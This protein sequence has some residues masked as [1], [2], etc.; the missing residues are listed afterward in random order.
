MKNIIWHNDVGK[1]VDDITNNPSEWFPEESE[2]EIPEDADLY[3]MAYE[4]ISNWLGDEQMNLDKDLSGLIV[5]TGT[6][7]TWREGFRGAKELGTKNLGESLSKALELF[8]SYDSLEIYEENG[9]LYLSQLGHDNPT[10]PSIMEFRM[11]KPDEELYGQAPRIL[12]VTEPL[13]NIPRDVYGW[14]K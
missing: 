7:Q 3:G 5:L 13:G 10:N 4:A 1:M 9:G 2:E 12:M 6:V 11:L 14:V 8:D